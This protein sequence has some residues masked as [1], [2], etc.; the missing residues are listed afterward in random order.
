MVWVAAA[1][2][3]FVIQTVTVLVAEYRKPAKTVSWLLV[4][5]VLPVVGFAL[6]GILASGYVRR[7][8]YA[9]DISGGTGYAYDISG[10]KRYAYDA[11][12]VAGRSNVCGLATSSANALDGDSWAEAL[13]D[14]YDR[15]TA[16]LRRVPQA[17]LRLYNETEVYADCGRVYEAMLEALEEASQHICFQFYTFRFDGVGRRF[18]QTLMRK[19]RSGVRVRF[20]YD[21]VGS[22][23]IDRARLDELRAAGVETRVFL[24]PLFALF[25]KRVNCRNHRKIVVIDGLTAF[26]GGINIGEE[27]VG[28]NGKLGYWRDTHLRIKGDAV[29]D[30]QQLFM[31]DWALAGGKTPE[32]DVFCFPEHG[33][34]EVQPMQLVSG[35]PNR[36]ADTILE[37]YVAAMMSARTSIYLVTPYFIPDPSIAMALKTAAAAGLDVRIICP[38]RPDSRFVHWASMS[39]VREMME[40]GVKCFRYTAGFIHAKVLIVDGQ[41]ACAGTSNMDMRS[42]FSNFE[43]NMILLHQPTVDRLL[44]DYEADLS[45]SEPIPAADGRS[46]LR[47]AGEICARLLSPLL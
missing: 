36:R 44:A 9:Y 29:R 14:E 12:D 19:A 7:T 42:F 26:V 4:M 45:K 40:E 8:R 32:S 37:V 1:A 41:F 31:E 16:Y 21:G 46:P 43:L 23:G 10:R 28:G 24:P 47:K 38:R 39:Y 5:T 11:Y 6:Y 30:I 35:G 17:P 13:P 33:I 20:M 15:L 22:Y 27:Y 25:H 34:R 18:Q 3:L 2:L